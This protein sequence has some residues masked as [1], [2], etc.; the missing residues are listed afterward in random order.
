MAVVNKIQMGQSRIHYEVDADPS[1]VLSGNAGDTAKLTTGHGEWTCLGT[2]TWARDKVYYDI[3]DPGDAAAIPVT[4]SGVC[5][6]TSGAVDETRTVADP[7]YD[8]QILDLGMDVD[9]GGAIEVTFASAFDS[10]GNTKATFGDAQDFASFRAADL[11]AALKWH[12]AASP[13]VALT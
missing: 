8:G 13:G 11:G 1:G 3:P 4:V 7:T 10:A 12:V 5:N 9:G 2:T 6:M